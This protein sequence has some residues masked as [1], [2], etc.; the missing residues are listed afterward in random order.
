MTSYPPSNVPMYPPQ[1]INTHQTVAPGL[2]PPPAR[3][4]TQ[5]SGRKNSCLKTA[6][7]AIFAILILLAVAGVLVWYFVWYQCLLGK[8][9]KSGGTCVSA[10]RWCDGVTDCPGGEDESHCFRLYGS[11]F[12][13]QGY[14]SAS[15]TWKPVCSDLWNDQFGQATCQQIGYSRLSYVSSTSANTGSLA[16]NGFLRLRSSSYQNSYVQGQLDNAD[17]CSTYKAV[18][19]RCIDCGVS[20]A[21]PR[22]RI[23]GGQAAARGAWPWQVS[24]HALGEHLC[25]GSIISPQWVLTAAHC[26][27]NLFIPSAWTVYAGYLSLYEMNFG[28]AVTRIV[29]HENYDTKTHNNDIALMKLSSPLIMSDTVK[30]VCL[31]N[32]GLNLTPEKQAWISGWGALRSGG[33]A[34][35][36]LMQAQVTTFSRSTCNRP[37][38]YDGD[39]T[40]SMI[41]AGKLTGGVDSCQGDSGGPLVIKEDVLW[42]LIG[43]TSWGV[44]CALRN[45]PGVYGNVSY[46]LDW[47]YTQLQDN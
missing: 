11:N 23:V 18:S 39:I 4:T 10:S 38:V 1:P 35:P 37:E 47:V 16:S 28:N 27:E 43:D 8:S 46:F 25:G 22:T 15:Q 14:S 45:K 19:L 44:G 41:C 26:V 32:V 13:L 7:I 30:P 36:N 21:A 2:P 31:P 5:I 17:Y 42:W 9:C 33:S 29:M 24:L 3:S 20:N 6:T 12:V 40:N 34:S